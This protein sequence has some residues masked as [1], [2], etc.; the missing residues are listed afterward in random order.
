MPIIQVIVFF[1]Q[2]VLVLTYDINIPHIGPMHLT[3]S[4][5]LHETC[6]KLMKYLETF[7]PLNINKPNILKY[8]SV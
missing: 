5:K 3:S 2:C 8:T 4:I 7:P 1:A 6:F